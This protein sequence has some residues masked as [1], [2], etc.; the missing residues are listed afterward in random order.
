MGNLP[1][2]WG[3]DYTHCDLCGARYHMSE[4]G[5]D[6]TADLDDCACGKNEWHRKR[7]PFCG[8]DPEAPIVCEACGTEPGAEP[9]V[10]DD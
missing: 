6:C 8:V 2:D 7:L 1:D 9:E 3:C 4:C 5:C 10:D